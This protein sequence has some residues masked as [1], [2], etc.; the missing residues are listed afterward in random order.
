MEV[1]YCHTLQFILRDG[2]GCYDKDTPSG[3][4]LF[5]RAPAWYGGFQVSAV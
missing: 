5:N 4:T 1:S 2:G 3:K